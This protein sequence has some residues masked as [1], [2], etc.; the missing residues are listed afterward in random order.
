[1]TKTIVVVPDIQY[2][3]HDRAALAAVVQF[4]ADTQPDEVVQIGDAL[5]FEGPARWTKDTREEYAFD[6]EAESEGLRDDFIKPVRAAYSGPFGMIEGNHDLRP[7]AYLE[8][9]APALQSKSRHF[10]FDVLCD[11]AAWDVELLPPFYEF[12]R[13]H[14]ATHGHLGRIGLRH[15]AGMTALGAAKRWGKSVIMGHTHRMAAIPF[16][17]GVGEEKTIWGVEAGNLMDP[18]QAGYLKGTPGNWQRGF[19]VIHCAKSGAIQPECIYFRPDNSFDYQ[20]QCWTPPGAPA[21]DANGRF[22]KKGA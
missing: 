22:T 11:F 10:H 5:D 7:R 16:T 13:G 9:Y 19:V 8:K 17:T 20:G 2:P 15:D 21:R 4:I 1:L 12:W 3:K 14:V 6:V 18:A